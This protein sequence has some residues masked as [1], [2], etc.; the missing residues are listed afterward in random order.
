MLIWPQTLA[1]IFYSSLNTIL[2]TPKKV[3]TSWHNHDTAQLNTIILIYIVC[4][5]GDVILQVNLKRNKDP[6]QNKGS[7]E[8]IN[9]FKSSTGIYL[10][11]VQ[12]D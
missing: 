4:I 1:L 6:I 7:R 2:Y 10:A 9:N 11:A 8:S 3:Q 12:V 5:K